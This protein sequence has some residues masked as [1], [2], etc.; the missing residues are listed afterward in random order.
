MRPFRCQTWNPAT[1]NHDAR[2]HQTL[3]IDPQRRSRLAEMT[4]YPAPEEMLKTICEAS[5]HPLDVVMV[6]LKETAK[7]YGIVESSVMLERL[8]CDALR[9]L[10]ND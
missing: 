4:G 6:G 8:Y 9:V 5:G 3:P 7:E 10:D 2:T 1:A